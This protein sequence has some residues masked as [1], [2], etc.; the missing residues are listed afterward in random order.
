M[1]VLFDYT[2]DGANYDTGT[3]LYTGGRLAM[4]FSLSTESG[5]NP[6]SV[7]AYKLNLTGFVTG[8]SL[9]G[10]LYTDSANAPG[11]MMANSDKTITVTGTGVQTFTLGAA[12]SLSTDPCW[13]VFEYGG[14]GSLEV[15][16]KAGDP[17][18]SYGYRIIYGTT[19]L[20]NSFIEAALEY[21]AGGG[22]AT[23]GSLYVHV[24][25]AL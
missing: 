9:K 23:G 20:D 11:S 7:T 8:G 14:T 3:I 16:G 25:K 22:A 19:T 24:R 17:S 15:S 10:S 4:K 18:W 21:T 2:P 5:P 6:C 12:Y 13:L 1:T